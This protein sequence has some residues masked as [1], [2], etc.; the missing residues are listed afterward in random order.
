MSESR[1]TVVIA[2]R[3]RAAELTR[4]LGC[5]S[6][7]NVPII[8]VDNGSDDDTVA[9]VRSGFP[10]VTVV[11]LRRNHG[12]VARN[13]G[14]RLASTPYV[15]F[16][17]DDSWW[18]N[19]ALRIAEA[20]FDRHPD[21]GLIAARTLVGEPGRPD[22]VTALLAD[23]PLGCEPDLPGPSVL[24]FL[25]CSALVRRRAFLD[26]GGFSPL[27]FFVGEERLLSWELAAAGW[28]LCYLGTVIAHHHPSSHRQPSSTRRRV[29]LRNRLLM[30]WLRRPAPSAWAATVALARSALTDPLAATA[31]ITA[32]SRL[33]RALA[34]RRVL[35][36]TVERQIALLEQE[37]G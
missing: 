13:I 22:P 12:A 18:A 24:G 34:G 14:A 36:T 30:A 15:A 6:G 2:T 35:P 33:P 9:M 16:S 10:S 25:G 28:K 27:L 26:V 19:G 5:L 21:V 1:T 11:P 23:S 20:A 8:V 4:T 29:E 31:L 17:D 37:H 3:N 32:L 7:L